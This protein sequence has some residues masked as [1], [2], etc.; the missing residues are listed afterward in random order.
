[1]GVVHIEPGFGVVT[2][3]ELSKLDKVF[4]VQSHLS[5]F[6]QLVTYLIRYINAFLEQIESLYFV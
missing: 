4:F 6:L 1:M 3:I 5:N 2:F